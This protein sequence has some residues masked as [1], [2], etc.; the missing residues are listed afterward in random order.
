M[1]KLLRR[2]EFWIAAS[3]TVLTIG[4]MFPS[5]VSTLLKTPK[6][7]ILYILN[8]TAVYQAVSN[9][10]ANLIITF[11]VLSGGYLIYMNIRQKK[12]SKTNNFTASNH[13]KSGDELESNQVEDGI[14]DSD[15]IQPKVVD[16]LQEDS[17]PGS[18]GDNDGL[19]KKLN[20][21][22]LQDAPTSNDDSL[23]EINTFHSDEDLEE[24]V[25][26]DEDTFT[27]LV[28]NSESSEETLKAQRIK[29]NESYTAAIKLN[30]NGSFFKYLFRDQFK[31][32]KIKK[33][34]AYLEEYIDYAREL[35][36]D[37]E[38]L[39]KSL[40]LDLLN[41][42]NENNLVEIYGCGLIEVRKGAR[43]THR[44]SS[45]SGSGGGGSIGFKGI[46]VGGGSY[47]G[48]SYSTSISYPAPDE[49]TLIDQG[50]FLLTNKKVSFV[51]GMFTKSTDYKKIVALNNQGNQVLIA[52]S[53]GSKVW[54][55]EFPTVPEQWFVSSLIHTAMEVD[56]KRLDQ[57]AVSIYGDIVRSIESSFNAKR[58]EIDVEIVDSLIDLDRFKVLY[59]KFAK[60]YSLKD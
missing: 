43:V 10:D 26:S 49:L 60:A 19:N 23:I 6:R 31:I 14:S 41:S 12:M 11:F 30:I 29:H 21:A 54:I 28:S 37:F 3:L 53:T 1:K 45:Y 27:E 52:P 36:S 58:T 5:F 48:S 15:V 24:F 20:L 57:S 13:Q 18:K 32:R 51:G 47:S 35:K 40:D 17:L 7:V 9:D 4:L 50:K 34:I 22:Y 42:K 44:E 8:F 46:R 59:E 55:V 2:P 39:L 16:N 38:N 25:C 56:E 33:K